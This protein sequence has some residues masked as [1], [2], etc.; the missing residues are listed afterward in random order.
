MT[1][2]NV[3]R[4]RS[5]KAR[6]N[7]A[8]SG[9]TRKKQK[10]DSDS[11]AYESEKSSEDVDT[12]ASGSQYGAATGRGRGRNS[13][14]LSGNFWFNRVVLCGVIA[15]VIGVTLLYT[16]VGDGT[17]LPCGC[18]RSNGS[19]EAALVSRNFGLTG[20]HIQTTT[21]SAVEEQLGPLPSCVTLHR[22]AD[23]LSNITSFLDRLKRD[24]RGRTCVVWLVEDLS[25]LRAVADSLKELLEDNSLRGEPI[26]GQGSRGL[27]VLLVK[28]SRDQLKD[29]LPHRV[30]HMFHS[31]S[32][33]RR[34]RR[35]N[36]TSQQT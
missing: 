9:S 11:T 10:S 1:G 20:L 35:N 23:P 22:L 31:E 34:G 26:L 8:V 15:V 4:E 16:I 25:V 19:L 18:C 28:E 2:K 13:E 21:Q 5:R 3:Q 29:V 32:Q 30:V 24:A 14:E 36:L 27:F 7:A 6:T 12:V 33:Y 17:A